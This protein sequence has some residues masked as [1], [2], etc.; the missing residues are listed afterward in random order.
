MTDISFRFRWVA[1]Q[2]D[3]LRSCL[4]PKDVRDQLKTLPKGLEETYER[5]LAKGCHRRDLLQMLH[6]LAFSVRAL[7]IEELAETGSVDLDAEGLPLYNPDL[8]YP[9]PH[10]ALAVCSGL[11]TEIDGAFFNTA[12]N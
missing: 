2:I 11:V 4:K 9:N 6:W 8:R 12:L 7:R 1:L 5:I 3:S 10:T